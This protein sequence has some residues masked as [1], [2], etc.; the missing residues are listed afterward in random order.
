MFPPRNK[1]KKYTQEG[2]ILMIIFVGYVRQETMNYDPRLVWTAGCVIYLRLTAL[3]RPL[4]LYANHRVKFHRML[5][6][7]L[8]T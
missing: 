8:T 6:R 2:S 4:K 5:T 7:N 1:K 3:M